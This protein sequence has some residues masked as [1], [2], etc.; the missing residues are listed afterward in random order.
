MIYAK[1]K[2]TNITK[3]KYMITKYMIYD[4]KKVTNITKALVKMHPCAN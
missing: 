4:K 2:V 1:K 3:A